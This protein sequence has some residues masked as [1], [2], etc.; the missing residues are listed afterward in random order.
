[1][2]IKIVS[3][4]RNDLLKRNEIIFILSHERSPTPSRIEVRKE[5]A[6]VLKTEIDKVY[7]RKI[8]TVT[9][10]TTSIGEAHIYD[11]LELVKQIEPE[12]II[13]RN[14]PQ[15]KKEE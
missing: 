4:R 3:S 12:H 9:G 15:V 1:M 8:E 6:K 2:K 13:I 7:I 10:T 5:I 14:T 11:S